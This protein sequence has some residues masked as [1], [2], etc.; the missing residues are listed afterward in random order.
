M[1]NF[2]VLTQL[3]VGSSSV[4][5][6]EPLPA[7]QP[8][9]QPILLPYTQTSVT[10]HVINPPEEAFT[11]PTHGPPPTYAPNIQTNPSYTQIPPNYPPVSMNVPLESQGPYYYF[12]AKLF[13]L[14]I[15][16][17]GKVE[18]RESS[19]PIDMNL[20][21]RLDRFDEFMRKSQG[22][23]KQGGLD[24]NELCLFPDMQL[25]VSFK[26]PK[27]SKYDGMGN[28]KTHLRMFVN[29]LGKPIDDENL[30]VR[31]FPESLEGDALD[32][33]SNLKPED[34][35]TWLD[36]STAFVRQYEYNYELA[37]TRT[38]LEGTKR[39]PSKDHKTYEKRWRKLA[40]KVEPPMTEEEI[41][42]TFI[43]THDPPYFEEIFRMT[44]CSFAE[45]VNKLEEYDEF[46]R[47]GKIVN[48]SALK[49]QLEAMQSQSSS[50][51]K[52]QF[53]KKEEEVS[54]RDEQGPSV[55]KNP[56]PTHKD[57]IEAI[58]IDEEIEKPTQYIVD[59]AEIMG[60][61][62][63]PFILEEEAYEVKENADPFIL[64]GI[65]F[66]CEP[67]ELVVLEFEPTLL[68]G[69][70]EVPKKE[71]AAI[72]RSGRIVGEPAVDE[73]SK[74]KENSAPTRPTVTEEEAF[75]FLRMLKKSKYRV[76]KQL[77][78]MPA[79]ISMLN[80][81]LT[82]KLH[83]E[84]LL[85]VLNEAQV[86]KNIPVDKF[87]HVVENVLASNQIS[88][89][90]EDLT[91][92]E[93]G[94]N[95]ALYISV[96]CN[97]KLLPRVL[98]D[99][100]SAL[101]ICPWN[102]LVKLGFQEAKL[103]QTATMVR[104]FD[105]AKRESMGE[106]DLVLEIGPAQ[107]QVIC[108]VMNFS[109]IYN[110]QLG[111]SWIHTSGAIPSSLH[112]MLRFVVNGQLITVFAEDDCTM[113]INPALDEGNDG[114]ALVSP[115]HMAD[116]ISVGWVPKD[117]SVMGTR[118]PEASIMMTKEMIRGG[119]EIGKSLGHN[120]QRILEPI[121]LQGKN[122]TFGLGFEPTAKDKKEMLDQV[123][124]SEVDPVEEVDIG[125]SELFVGVTYEGEPS[126]DP[127]FPE[128][129]VEAMKNWTSDFLPSRREIRW[130]KTKHIDPL[131]ITIP[132]FDDCNL[133]ISHKFKILESEIQNERDNEEESE[134][135][136][137]NLEQYE[138]KPKLNLEE[139]ETINIGTKTEVEEIKISVHF[140]KGQRKEM[141]EFLTMFQDVFAWSYDDM[142]GIS[143][144]IVAHRLPTDPNFPL[145]KQKPR[146]FKLDMSLKIKEQI[147]KQLNAR[148][149]MVPHY[150]I[151]FS[152]P[153][154]IPKKIGK[155]RVCVDYRD[156]NKASPKDDF[157]LPNIHILL[158]NTAGHEIESFA[159]CFAGI[160]RS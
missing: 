27:F 104:G 134:S 133:N 14:D 59:E 51:K 84:A 91:S 114:K 71:V 121:E 4:G 26:A 23:S 155:V 116:I 13:T 102:T 18:A 50:S 40:A 25:P 105:G 127:K 147:E 77:D 44:E 141:I 53:K 75:N 148:I 136:L 152:N 86:P 157:P 43:K 68:N 60:V 72:T 110:I 39:K 24:Y 55:S 103:R 62:G 128:I 101:N 30:P 15:A 108:Q 65:P 130:P 7:S 32:W 63:E 2:R 156:L 41:V 69:G 48:V 73:P 98:I 99:N 45:I 97:G 131:D 21:K 137:K 123:I 52:S 129:P 149:I 143:T 36:L 119:Y 124:G 22:L 90:D 81:L 153:V 160:T 37:P 118:I 144:D 140:N 95:K 107:F 82:S 70:E 42:H 6:P 159:N 100:G 54:F 49:S 125:L 61:I 96:C 126:E 34:M 47:A 1:T 17:Q 85:K 74:A 16:A 79:Q 150:P 19:T 12:T 109:S 31:L 57:T 92:K 10:S 112:Q 58:I 142:P 88:F 38:T 158:D 9:T 8:E 66:E 132:E 5:Q 83:R 94:H 122:D 117:K 29:K 138:E 145:V 146:K 120:L 28:P 76:I 80:L 151:W 64:N 33:Y 35:R 3:V 56:L 87:T 67:S 115:H 106:M 78:K 113:I 11:Y 111:Q 139:I 135:L 93:I 20:L 154:P 89:S 46:V